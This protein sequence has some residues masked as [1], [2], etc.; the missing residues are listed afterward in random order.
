[1]NYKLV[2]ETIISKIEKASS[3]VIVPSA[4]IDLDCIGSAFMMKIICEKYNPNAFIEIYSDFQVDEYHSFVPDIKTILP[5]NKDNADLMRFDL[6]L[7]VD[8]CTLNLF[9]AQTNTAYTLIA[10]SN[11]CYIDHHIYEDLDKNVFCDTTQSS[12]AEVIFK[13][14]EDEDLGE[15][16]YTYAYLGFLGDTYGYRWNKGLSTFQ[17][18]LKIVEK[19]ANYQFCIDNFYKINSFKSLKAKSQIIELVEKYQKQKNIALLIFDN[20]ILEKLGIDRQEVN[21][22]IEAITF[23]LQSCRDIDI[24]IRLNYNNKKSLSWISTR[25]SNATNFSCIEFVKHLCDNSGRHGGHIKAAGANFDAD[26]FEDAKNIL[27]AKIDSFL[28]L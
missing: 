9:S 25:A 22:T 13:L 26:T 12:C 5:L 2:K 24:I 14:F 10:P 16:F 15:K 18:G 6:G 7:F 23:D 27:K 8:G 1:M 19:G 17:N 11:I 4:R 3:I 28:N 21:Q 20:E